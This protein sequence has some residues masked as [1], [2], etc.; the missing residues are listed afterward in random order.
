MTITKTP[1]PPYYAVIFTSIRSEVDEG[2]SEMNDLTEEKAA[3]YEGYLG[4]EYFRNSD[5]FG[6]HISYWTD[7]ESIDRWRH[8]ELHERAKEMG[9]KKWYKEY[10]LRISKVEYDSGQK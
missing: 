9:R 1:S 2:Y 10:K 6:I 7:L 8:D 4:N 5:G 3:R